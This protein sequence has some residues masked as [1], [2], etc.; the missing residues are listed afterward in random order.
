MK[1]TNRNTCRCWES[2]SPTRINSFTWVEFCCTS[3]LKQQTPD[4]RCWACR[5]QRQLWRN[6][7][8]SPLVLGGTGPDYI[9]RINV[10]EA[11]TYSSLS[12]LWHF[13]MRWDSDAFFIQAGH[14]Q[15]REMG[16]SRL[17]LVPQQTLSCCWLMNHVSAWISVHQLWRDIMNCLRW[18]NLWW[19]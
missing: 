5:K 6:L 7:T 2:E 4:C 12:W 16:T 11:D 13:H 17:Q 15:G 19:Q 9:Q 14:S 1:K 8:D 10:A 18:R 3:S